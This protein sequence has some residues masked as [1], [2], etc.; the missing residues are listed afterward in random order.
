[1]KTLY[2][3]RGNEI[4]FEV[5][6]LDIDRQPMAPPSAN[7]TV[8]FKVDGVRTTVSIPMVS[9]GGGVFTASWKSHVADPGTVEW[10]A[11]TGDN[12]A[13]QDGSFQLIANNANPSP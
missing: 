1:M 12:S 13:A 6:F 8:A 4:S 7:L 9:A 5:S 11:R 2:F 10:H 3:A